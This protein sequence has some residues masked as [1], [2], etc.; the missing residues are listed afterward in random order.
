MVRFS[1]DHCEPHRTGNYLTSSTYTSLKCHSPVMNSA[2]SVLKVVMISRW[3]VFEHNY[4]SSP[5]V[6]RKSTPTRRNLC[7]TRVELKVCTWQ[8]TLVTK[9]ICLR[10]KSIKINQVNAKITEIHRWV[11]EVTPC[12]ESTPRTESHNWTGNS[13]LQVNG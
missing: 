6:D 12:V 8:S 13:R 5:C 7:T 11:Q 2:F 1:Y 4:H 3:S 9:R 10:I